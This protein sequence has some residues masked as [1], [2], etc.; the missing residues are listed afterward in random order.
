MT[1]EMKDLANAAEATG[2]LKDKLFLGVAGLSFDDRSGKSTYSELQKEFA[3]SPEGVKAYVREA[4][5]NCLAELQNPDSP[6][7]DSRESV[8]LRADD[9]LLLANDDGRVVDTTNRAKVLELVD[10][11]PSDIDS[12]IEHEGSKIH[13]RCIQTLL[14][15]LT[16]D[17][18]S[19]E[20]VEGKKDKYPKEYWIGRKDITGMDKF[21]G[22][23]AAYEMALGERLDYSFLVNLAIRVQVSQDD[24][25]A[26]LDA[27]SATVGS[28]AR[29]K[30]VLLAIK[31]ALDAGAKGEIDMLRLRD[32]SPDPE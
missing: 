6:W 16:G 27:E 18:P 17:K 28:D 29:K 11:V 14:S 3:E 4:L 22:V 25:R 8:D 9:L 19:K 7:Y 30:A 12:R 32:I 13:D 1:T 21:Y 24:W 23:K 26:L 10:A 31:L 2:Y 20:F 5:N 15:L